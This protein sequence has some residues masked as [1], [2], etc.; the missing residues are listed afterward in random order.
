MTE[1]GTREQ[2]EREYGRLRD[3]LLNARYREGEA[4]GGRFYTRSL[5]AAV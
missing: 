2:W 3:A 1:P 4:V 5:T